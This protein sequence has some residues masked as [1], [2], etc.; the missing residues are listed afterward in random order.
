[1]VRV[2]H[3]N[4]IVTENSQFH[5]LTQIKLQYSLINNEVVNFFT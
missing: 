1:M 4:T 3:S 2:S 5:L